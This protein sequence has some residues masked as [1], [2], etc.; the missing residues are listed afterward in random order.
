MLRILLT[1]AA[2][3]AAI[4]VLLALRD[5]A[6]H[7]RASRTTTLEEHRSATDALDSAPGKATPRAYL[8]GL[9]FAVLFYYGFPIWWARY[10]LRRAITLTLVCIC[11]VGLV[12]YLLVSADFIEIGNVAE[13]FGAGLLLAVPIRAI[14]GLYVAKHDSAWRF[15]I[16][17]CRRRRGQSGKPTD[18]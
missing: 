11:A 1:L 14:A 5:W 17:A 10:G 6:R 18:A 13:S 4:Y 12:Q 16:L 8:W 3:S 9:A 2:A 7:A 15:A